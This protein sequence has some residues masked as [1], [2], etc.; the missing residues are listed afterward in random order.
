MAIAPGEWNMEALYGAHAGLSIIQR[1]FRLFGPEFVDTL[2]NAPV[3]S[4]KANDAF[5]RR[6]PFTNHP[7]RSPECQG[8]EASTAGSPSSFSAPGPSPSS[9]CSSSRCSRSSAGP[10]SS[11][12]GGN[13]AR[14][15]ANRCAS[16]RS[17]VRRGAS[18]WSTA[19][20]RSTATARSPSST[21]PPVRSW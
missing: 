15:D 17:S 21:W 1:L 5:F 12:S 2:E 18:R 9:S 6:S 10:S 7:I 20:P 16:A 13:S 19:R 4:K 3:S 8:Q 11:R 14:S